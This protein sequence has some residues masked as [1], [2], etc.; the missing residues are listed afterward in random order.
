MQYD[1]SMHQ[2]LQVIRYVHRKL[3]I[4]HGFHSALTKIA[5]KI[6]GNL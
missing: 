1:Y 3:E 2:W 5:E 6:F 4:L